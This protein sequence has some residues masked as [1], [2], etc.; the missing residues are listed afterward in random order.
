M[1]NIEEHDDGYAWLDSYGKGRRKRQ[2]AWLLKKRLAISV[3]H[4]SRY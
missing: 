4:R 1:I 2:L 3:G